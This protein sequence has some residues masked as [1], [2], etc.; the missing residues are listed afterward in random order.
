MYLLESPVSSQFDCKTCGH[1]GENYDGVFNWTATYR[2]ESDIHIPYFRMNKLEKPL[3]N[4][5]QNYATNKTRLV[6]WVVSNCYTQSKRELYVRELAKYIPIDQY[7]SCNNRICQN[8]GCLKSLGAKHK[9]YLAFEN[10]LCDDYYTEKIQN[11]LLNDMVP[12]VLGSADY[13][14]VLPHGSYINIL[15]FKSPKYLA[16]Y[17]K[18]LDEND[19][20]Y[21]EFFS[22]KNTYARP[23]NTYVH[24]ICSI[25][26][27]LNEDNGTRKTYDKLSEWWNLYNCVGPAKFYKSVYIQ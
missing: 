6:L 4:E 19:A 2:P 21:N 14:K 10:S 1:F 9:F 18:L 12:I 15:S 5:F 8:P 22:W 25:C 27:Q 23:D 24:G 13:S 7:G 3:Y 20:L 26:E 17:L 11:A 16:D